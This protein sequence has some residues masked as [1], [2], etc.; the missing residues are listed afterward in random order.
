MKT[1]GK[2]IGGCAALLALGASLVAGVLTLP[3]PV[4]HIAAAEGNA[5]LA[6]TYARNE[7]LVVKYGL[8]EVK[9]GKL[10]AY[11]WDAET[12]TYVADP[13]ADATVQ[14]HVNNAN[15]GVVEKAEGV[16]G[17]SAL[18][19]TGK[20][21]AR[22]S[23]HLPQD[24]EGMTVSIWVKNITTYWGSLVEF[25]DGKD[26]GRFGKGTMQ[27]NAGRANEGDPW[28]ENASAHAV[29]TMEAGA[30]WD[31]FV[32]TH[33]NTN[34]DN[35][36]AYV[37]NMKPDTWYQVTYTVTST[38]MRA[39]RDGVLKQTFTGKDQI[40]YILGS[41]MTAA[42]NQTTGKLGIRLAHDTTDDRADILDDFRIYSG[43][44]WHGAL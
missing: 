25:Y 31:S 19:F 4:S 17:S 13:A 16:E 42:K 24:A 37:D 6:A 41:I 11:K 15:T 40:P 33:N 44:R 3:K 28:K 32:V 43:G 8:D 1:L 10:P 20:A 30:G 21:H 27:G 9:D 35:G 14:Y 2:R 22:A 5:D 38:E 23:F 39:Y 18:S 7:K 12:K 34:N 26:G 29:G 36:G